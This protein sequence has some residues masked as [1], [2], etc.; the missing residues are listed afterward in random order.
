MQVQ[1]S[2]ATVLVT[3]ATGGLGSAIARRIHERG[4]RLILTGRRDEELSA[5]AQEL[6]ARSV[7]AD[8]AVRDDVE[9][10]A[11]QAGPVDILIANAAL[12][13]A[14]PLTH[15]TPDEIDRV[16]DVNLRAPVH[17][18][19]AMIDA[20][21]GH[22]VFMS[23]IGGRAAV[24]GN[25]LYHATKFALRGLSGALRIDLRADGIGVSCVLPA[26]IRDAG[27]YA[28]SGASLPPG[29]GT[30]SP[31][32]VADAVV[33]AIER[34]RAE[35]DVSPLSLRLGAF[36]WDLAP[37]L[38]AAVASRLGSREIALTYERG[39]RAKR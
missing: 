2:G 7:L 38:S 10:L 5:L 26:F 24:P 37:D 22:I 13:G 16:I 33:R 9:L 17:L 19:P 4:G 30:R 27:M 11:A 23:S 36:F 14:A 29:I 39:L 21:R 32:E 12:P 3:G 1:I 28:E 6:D 35:I 34:N 8:L 31:G 20:G 18:V 15:L 25:P